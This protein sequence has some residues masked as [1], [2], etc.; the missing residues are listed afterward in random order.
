MTEII[1]TEQTVSE[2]FISKVLDEYKVASNGKFEVTDNQR[3]IIQEYFVGIDDTLKAAEAKRLSMVAAGNKYASDVPVIWQNVNLNQ[4]A[5][6]SV[7]YS[8]LGLSMQAKNHLY[9]IPFFNKTTQKYDVNFMQGYRGMGYL[10]QKFAMIPFRN[11]V[12]ELVY[13]NDEF[14]VVKKAGFDDDGDRYEFKIT[15]PFDRGQPVGGFGYVQYDDKSLNR[16]YTISLKDLLKRKPKNASV[17]F[18]GGEKDKWE[19]G[20]KVGTEKI[21]GWYEQMLLKTLM[22]FVYGQIELDPSKVTEEFEYIR[23]REDEIE[24]LQLQQEIDDNA[25]S[26]LI[27]GETGEVEANVPVDF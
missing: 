4:L 11:V 9:P 2:R 24:K 22:R 19:K 20:K 7:Y 14:N 15:N 17:E 5:L 8:R 16:L 21:E 18:W 27:D 3:R 23:K 25:G 12:C 10:A 6:D 26:V 1:K 13:S